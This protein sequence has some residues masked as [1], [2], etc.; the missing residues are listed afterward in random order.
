MIIFSENESYLGFFGDI[1]YM[2]LMK[3][4]KQNKKHLQH[5]RR[6]HNDEDSEE[7]VKDSGGLLSST[8]S[9]VSATMSNEDFS[10]LKNYANM[11]SKR[12]DNLGV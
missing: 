2:I 7:N 3:T 8:S 12:I 10:Q 4:T 5:R 1:Q 11:L 9:D 6:Y